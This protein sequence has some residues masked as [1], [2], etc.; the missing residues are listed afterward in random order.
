MPVVLGVLCG[1]FLGARVL[2]GMK[3]SVL[4]HVFA[5]VIAVLAIEM[6][7]RGLKGTV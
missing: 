5:A 7:F 1:S 2:P 6:I 3:T 4:R